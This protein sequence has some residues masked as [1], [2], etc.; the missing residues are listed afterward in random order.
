[1]KFKDFSLDGVRGVVAS[2]GD[3]F[4]T[5]DVSR[6]ATIRSMHRP[7]SAEEHT[8]R[9]MVGRYLSMRRRELDLTLTPRGK[10]GRGRLW[11]KSGNKPLV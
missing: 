4:Y 10:A 8:Y 11:E 5:D 3:M 1:M 9:R 6:Q 7:L 2:M